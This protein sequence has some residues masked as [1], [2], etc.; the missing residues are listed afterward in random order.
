MGSKSLNCTKSSVSRPWMIDSQPPRPLNDVALYET[1]E[2]LFSY[3][4]GAPCVCWGEGRLSSLSSFD[5]RAE[6]MQ[7][8]HVTGLSW[9]VQERTLEHCNLLKVVNLST[10]FHSPYY[11]KRSLS[12]NRGSGHEQLAISLPRRGF[13]FPLA[14]DAFSLPHGMKF[15]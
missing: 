2:T 5:P 3:I 9:L 4:W 13:E 1:Y 15:K 7:S 8:H 14:R 10:Q 12:K 6:S 11:P